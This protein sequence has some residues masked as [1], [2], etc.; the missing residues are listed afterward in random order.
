MNGKTRQSETT[1]TN[2]AP[3]S[4]AGTWIGIVTTVLVIIGGIA[5]IIEREHEAHKPPL[6]TVT[7]AHK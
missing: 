1:S 6:H 5:M 4:R 3:R 7:A 2:H